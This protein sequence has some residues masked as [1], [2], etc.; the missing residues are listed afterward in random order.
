MGFK[1]GV[2]KRA[3]VLKAALLHMSIAP[4]QPELNLKLLIDLIKEAAAKG[5]KLLV[6]PE[7]A[8]SGYCFENRESILPYAQDESGPALKALRSL[9]AKLK[10]YLAVGLAELAEPA[11]TL[12]NS[13]FFLN[14]K[15]RILGRSRKINS[16]SRWA[17]PGDQIQ[18]N[19]WPTPWGRVG[20]HI[21]ADSWHSL[22]TRVTA[23]KGAE[24]LL[25]PANWPQSGLD[26]TLLWR[27]RALENGLWFLACNRT[28][29]EKNLDCLA[30]KSCAFDPYGQEI[31]VGHSPVSQV[32]LVDL[33]LDE[34][35]RV[36]PKRRA[37]IMAQRQ[38]GQY[39]RLYGNFNGVQNLTGFLKLP[40]PGP[41]AITAIIPKP[42]ESL[43]SYF[44]R[45]TE[46][47][48]KGLFL[49]PPGAFLKSEAESSLNQLLAGQA[50]LTKTLAGQWRFWGQGFSGPRVSG[51][52]DGL[53]LTDFPPLR[54]W[55]AEPSEIVQPEAAVAAAK[56]GADVAIAMVDSLT[57]AF[58]LLAALRPIDQLATVVVAP[59]GAAMG[60]PWLG[61]DPGRG[62]LVG[63]GA[64][65]GLTVD[66]HETREKRFQ[67]RLDF[68]ALMKPAVL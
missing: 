6:A 44:S 60:L 2:T 37:E 57:P 62:A 20:L 5:A 59:D 55:L 33:P 17:A 10:V 31:F 35:G 54:I 32:Y 14:D 36:S 39:H 27:F 66:S 1:D 15:G 21:C 52:T 67:D 56:W 26:P 24:I 50:A 23:V 4:G 51:G 58:K 53:Y 43:S 22:I 38:V 41:L 3:K 8:F 11:G 42:S 63:V 45:L 34:N 13:A 65:G 12:Y 28:G 19:V 48:A 18:D 64:M 47:D 30:A 40:D 7:M 29:Q 9:T 61:H 25:L 49:W 16:E 46:P 68:A